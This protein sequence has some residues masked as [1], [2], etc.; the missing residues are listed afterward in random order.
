VNPDKRGW[1]RGKKRK[2]FFLRQLD[3]SLYI[4]GYLPASSERCGLIVVCNYSSSLT[5]GHHT[6]TL[7]QFIPHH[8]TTFFSS[9]SGEVTEDHS[10][11]L[12]LG[13]VHTFSPYKFIKP[14]VRN[15]V[16]KMPHRV[17]WRDRGGGGDKGKLEDLVIYL[18][19]NFTF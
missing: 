1:G 14:K 3:V 12:F 2:F 19:F 11:P 9:L 10:I 4:C 5:H 13:T 15:L 17:A 18:H 16:A 6:P 7:Q 8:A